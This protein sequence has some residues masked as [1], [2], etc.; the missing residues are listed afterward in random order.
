MKLHL[1]F[2][3]TIKGHLDLES[4]SSLNKALIQ[5]PEML[6]VS[7]HDF[8]LLNTVVSRVIEVSDK[9][10]VDYTG[11]FKEFVEDPKIKEKRDALY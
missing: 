3:C 1:Y 5:F 9:G 8:E 6:M 11:S 2:N 7:S 4:I 10:F